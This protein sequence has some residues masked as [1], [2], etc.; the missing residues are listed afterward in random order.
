MEATPD[1]ALVFQAKILAVEKVMFEW[2]SSPA[3]RVEYLLLRHR[4]LEI[5]ADVVRPGDDYIGYD[6]VGPIFHATEPDHYAY[7]QS[8]T[9]RDHTIRRFTEPLVTRAPTILSSCE[10]SLSHDCFIIDIVL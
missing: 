7:G 8:F 1:V 6:L 5:L 10:P 9:T 4:L 3:S 2:R